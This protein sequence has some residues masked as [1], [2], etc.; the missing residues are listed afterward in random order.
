MNGL[1]V[2]GNLAAGTV[3]HGAEPMVSIYRLM[4]CYQEL[5]EDMDDCVDQIGWKTKGLKDGKDDPS[6]ELPTKT[7]HVWTL[8]ENDPRPEVTSH[9][10]QFF[11]YHQVLSQKE[12]AEAAYRTITKG[13]LPHPPV[14]SATADLAKSHANKDAAVRKTAMKM[15]LLRHDH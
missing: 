15:L 5:S 9:L 13:R 8:P 6:Q 4:F 1:H 12:M 3:R 10:D 2:R 7:R 11:Q 14:L